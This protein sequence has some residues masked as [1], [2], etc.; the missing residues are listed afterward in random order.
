MPSYLY[1]T[2]LPNGEGGEIFEIEHAM[3]DPMLQK[4]PETKV[5]IRRIYLPPHIGTKHSERQSAALLDNGRIEKAGF[6]K[7]IRNKSDGSYHKI[8]GKEGPERFVKGK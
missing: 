1:E 2:V 6:T 5:P 3:S 4:H 7:Y 8:A